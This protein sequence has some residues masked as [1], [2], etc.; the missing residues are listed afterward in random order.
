MNSVADKSDNCDPKTTQ[1]V[2]ARASERRPVESNRDI[3]PVAAANSL[4][5]A[6]RSSILLVVGLFCTTAALAADSPDEREI[7][8]PKSLVS[9]SVKDAAPIPIDD[10]FYT[11]SVRGGAWSPDGEEIVFTTNLTGRYNLWKVS[12]DRGWPIQLSQSD[13][14]QSGATW[15]P[16]GKW[17]AYEADRGGDEMYDVYAIPS[18]GGPVVNLTN[19]P[20][21]S[22]TSATWAPDGKSLG[23]MYK[24]KASPSTDIAVLDWGTHAVRNLTREKSADHLWSN[25]AWSP[26]GQFIYSTR[27]NAEFTDSDVHQIDVATGKLENLTPHQGE[28]R[29]IVGFAR[30]QNLAGYLGPAGRLPEC[31]PDRYRYQK[32]DLD[33]RSE[34]GG[35]SR[36]R[37]PGWQTIYL[38]C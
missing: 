23:I 9:Q 15:S 6:L 26:D 37:F 38:L 5:S 7:T 34:M 25:M 28:V 31:R 16:D 3:N 29:T 21:V 10:L 33:H 2:I 13:D 18:D 36:K 8:D 20:D 11:R 30:W 32:A 35:Y 19:T 27:L 1:A 24:P 12:S 22:E 14:R 4:I 17:I